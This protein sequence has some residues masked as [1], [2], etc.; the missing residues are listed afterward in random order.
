M[1]TRVAAIWARVSS[2]GQQDLSLSGQVERVKA[3]L[4]NLSYI[5]QYIFK[6]VWSST[7]LKPCPQFQEL[8]Q[9]IRDQKIRAVGMLDRDRI[10]ANGL[11]RLNFLADCKQKEV[12][13]IV[14]QGVPFLDGGEGQ[15]VELALALAKEKQIERAQSGAKQGLADRAQKDGLPPTKSHVYG[16]KW[17]NSI[18]KYAP[19]ENHENA[20]LVWTLALSGKKFKAI[21]KELVLRGIPTPSGKIYWHKST[22]HTILTN[23]IYAG[24]YA[25]L[26]YERVE[27]KKRTKNTFGKTSAKLKP[28]E[29]WHFID[30]LVEQPIVTWQEFLTVKERLRLNQQAAKRNAH[31]D[32]LL[33]G[34]IRCELCQAQGIHRHYYG[35]QRT[36]QQPAYVCSAGWSQ[37]YGKRCPSKAI[38]CARLE[39]EVKTVIQNFLES[40]EFYLSGAQAEV[41]LQEKT[42]T[43]IEQKIRDNEKAYRKTIADEQYKLEKLTPEAFEQAQKLL[44][45]R[46]SYLNEENQGL[47]AKLNNLRQHS[48]NEDMVRHMRD[49][50]MAN[51]DGASA[52]DWRFILESLGAKVM[53]FG[54]GTWDIEINIPVG[55]RIPEASIVSKT[56]CCTSLC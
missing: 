45:A 40:P 44:V 56:G 33:R 7:D 4:E 42:I 20:G 14:Y 31:R 6:V 11:Q 23:P 50:L 24:R 15:L 55:E 2:E 35:V 19:D 37:T 36:K 21:C 49:N 30:D 3:K 41:E 9:L 13:P 26:R 27:P 28:V 25:A 16:M 47:K 54:D 53:A 43:E 52:E 1:E 5:P 48:V 29:E 8:R 10:E 46:R 39:D 18:G 38:P 22:L 17:D 32:Y 12:E 51:L 34:L